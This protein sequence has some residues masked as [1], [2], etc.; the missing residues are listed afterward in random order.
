MISKFLRVSLTLVFGLSLF[1]LAQTTPAGNAGSPAAVPNAPSAAAAVPAATGTKVG[2][3]NIEGAIFNSNEGRR[4]FDALTK[5]LE[6]KQTELKT[7]SDEIDSLKKQ[8]NTQGE[9][10]NED[11]RAA[12]VKQIEAKQKLFDRSVQDARE[13]AQGQQNEIMQ[14]IL[15]KLAPVIMKYAADNGYGVLLDTSQPWPQGPVIPVT[16]TMDI[17]QPVVDAYNVKSGVAAPPGSSAG[18]T[19]PASAPVKPATTP[20]SKPAT[21]AANKPPANKT[22]ANPPPKN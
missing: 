9:K 22:P 1:A 17:T 6:P 4:D 5:K 3:I 21:P 18:A 10:M 15:A 13:E 7:M 12:L 11:A 20:A 14:R 2:T 16:P 8:L 19:K